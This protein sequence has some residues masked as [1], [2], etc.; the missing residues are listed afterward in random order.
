[1]SGFQ[2][3]QE[4]PNSAM[5]AIRDRVRQESQWSAADLSGLGPAQSYFHPIQRCLVRIVV[6]L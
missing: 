4:A 2:N 3:P 6:P 1:M 5:K